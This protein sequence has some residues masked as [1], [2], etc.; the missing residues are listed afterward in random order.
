MFPTVNPHDEDIAGRALAQVYALLIRLAQ[1]RQQAQAQ[2][3]Q[4]QAPAGDAPAGQ[5]VQR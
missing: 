3:Q 2:A 5:G 4:Q 1:E